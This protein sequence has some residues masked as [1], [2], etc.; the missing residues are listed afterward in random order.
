MVSLS[1]SKISVTPV[2]ESSAEQIS[3]CITNIIH[4][5]DNNAS[6]IAYSTVAVW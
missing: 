5:P 2:S 4:C 1:I 3:Q 6:D